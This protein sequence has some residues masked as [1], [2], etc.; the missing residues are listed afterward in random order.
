VARLGHLTR[1]F[2]GSLRPGGPKAT[3][4]QWAVSQ[5]TEGEAELWLSMT[6]PD[7][8]HSVAVARRV[9]RS[10]GHEATRPVLAAALLHDVGKT[11]CGL[12][13]YGR[14]IATVSGAAVG[15]DADT[16][17]AWTRTR[18]FTRQVGLY[19]QHPKLGG[20]LLGM[21][22]SDPLTEAW[23]REHHLPEEDWTVPL[24]TGRALREADDD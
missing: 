5:L 9:E 18:G 19:L 16:I 4:T 22:D 23:A 2:V 11:Q 17:K 8:R 14:V 12:G 20:D 21:A 7:R 24:D 6:G 13:T 10:L 3:E 1:R 15:R